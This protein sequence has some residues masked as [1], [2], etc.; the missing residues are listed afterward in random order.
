MPSDLDLVRLAIGDTD[1]N[2]P[3]L[4]D[5]EVE[6]FLGQRAVI[7]TTGGTVYN[8]PA[9]AA[10][11]AGAIAAKFARQFSFSEDGQRFDVAQRVGHYQQLEKTLRARSG[12]VSVALS[13][14]GTASV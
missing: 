12:G 3:Q 7:D 1:E 9:A 13:L 5:S 14:G 4:L 2:D 6:A 11:C 8:I 10:D